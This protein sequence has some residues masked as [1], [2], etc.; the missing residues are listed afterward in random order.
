DLS[1]AGVIH[2]AAVGSQVHPLG[3]AGFNDDI[4]TLD[5]IARAVQ[6][7]DF[8][9]AIGF[10]NKYKTVAIDSYAGGIAEISTTERAG[11]GSIRVEFCDC[12]T[13][14]Q[15]AIDLPVADKKIAVSI[16]CNAIGHSLNRAGKGGLVCAIGG[17]YLDRPVGQRY[18]K[19][20]RLKACRS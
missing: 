12:V 16:D 20:A 5:H 2:R 14:Q 4:K 6:L 1:G 15:V 17:A 8:P 18:E 9:G 10:T 3:A 13:D 7:I 19:I 11:E